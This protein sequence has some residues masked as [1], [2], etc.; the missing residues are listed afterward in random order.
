MTNPNSTQSVPCS[1]ADKIE[2][3]GRM[4]T[5]KEVAD[6]LAESPKTTYARVKRGSQPATLVGGTIKFDPFETAQWL[7]NQTA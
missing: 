7:R 6:L 2:R 5:V 3:Y 4:L 1:I